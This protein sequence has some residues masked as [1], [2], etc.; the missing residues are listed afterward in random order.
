MEKWND[1]TM[2][3]WEGRRAALKKLLPH[4]R[5]ENVFSIAGAG[6]FDDDSVCCVFLDA[7]FN[8]EPVEL[9]KSRR[10]KASEIAEMRRFVIENVELFKAKWDEYFNNK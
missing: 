5:S 2:E 7:K 3:R 6:G 8:L 1:G 4:F 9:I 10:F